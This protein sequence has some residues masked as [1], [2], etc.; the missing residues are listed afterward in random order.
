MST[1]TDRE[2]L[3]QDVVLHDSEYVPSDDDPDAEFGG[4][5]QRKVMEK[6]MLRR[7][8]LR[9]SILVIIYILNYVS[10]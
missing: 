10:A 4:Q 3:P 8:D 6:R 2:K 7:L 9:M 5:E 1:S